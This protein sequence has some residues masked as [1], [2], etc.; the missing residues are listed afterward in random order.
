[1]AEILSETGRVL[2]FLKADGKLSHIRFCEAFPSARKSYPLREIT[3]AVFFDKSA[4]GELYTGTNADG[5]KSNFRNETDKINLMFF[6]PTGL[7]SGGLLKEVKLV[8]NEL[9]RVYDKL[10]GKV[11]VSRCSYSDK[12]RALCVMAQYEMTTKVKYNA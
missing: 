1:M 2:R 7:T 10:M 12:D 3:V 9:T 11:S 4:I 5:T 6:A 8:L